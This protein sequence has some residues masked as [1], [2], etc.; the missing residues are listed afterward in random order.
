LEYEKETKIKSQEARKYIFKNL[1]D[2]ADVKFP[3]GLSGIDKRAEKVDRYVPY[4]LGYCN[5]RNCP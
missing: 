4:F 1:N 3:S 2:I 5:P